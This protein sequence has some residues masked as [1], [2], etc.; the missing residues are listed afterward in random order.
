MATTTAP[1]E[2][3]LQ[4]SGVL[5]LAEIRPCAFNVRRHFDPADLAGLAESI[6]RIGLKE[7]LLVRPIDAKG[8]QV[9]LSAKEWR[10]KTAH[11]E[12][13]D[14]ARRWRALSLLAESKDVPPVPVIVRNLTDEEVRAIMLASREQSRELSVGDLV[15]G[16]AELRAKLPDDAAL[17]AMVGRP[18]SHVRGVLRLGKLP[19][20]VLAAVDAGT[21]PRA[22]ADLVAR[23]PGE[24]GKARC[25]ALVLH[26]FPHAEGVDVDDLV[27]AA[28]SLKNPDPLSY[29]ETKGLIRHEFQVELKDA[30]FS[31]KELYA[32][33][34]CEPGHER[35]MPDCE[36]CPSRAANDEEAKAEG[37]RGD[38]CL[39]VGCYRAKVE[40]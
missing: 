35:A 29:R 16:Y 6:D 39:D 12:L 18:V 17:A 3:P 36:A 30:P 4:K 21:L 19:G 9:P 28:P 22:T 33:P 5:P 2:P 37:T 11:F 1:A 23:V 7:P 38:V 10:K 26:G 31:R 25:A 15:V 27:R 34:G 14:G 13:A 24:E 32:W 8:Q 40:A 20:W